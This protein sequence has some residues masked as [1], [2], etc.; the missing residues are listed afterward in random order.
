MRGSVT[1]TGSVE[2][3]GARAVYVRA[4]QGSPLLLIH[5][6]IGG[7]GIWERNIPAL[8]EHR[9]VYAPDL[10]GMGH[11][12]RVH[13]LAAGLEP[14]ARR[15]LAA[16]DA[17]QIDRADVV[18]TSHGGSVALMLAA[19]A[20]E[21]VTSLILLAPAN[22]YS[23]KTD[24]MVRLYSTALGGWIANFA[25]RMP[26]WIQRVALARMFGDRRRMQAGTLKPYHD[27]LQVPGTMAHVLAMVR[28][29]FAEMKKLEAVLPEVAKTPTLLVW[30]DRDRVVSLK[31]AGRLQ[32][33]IGAEL[34]VI[35]GG[36]H[37]VF[38]EFPQETNRI[39]TEWLLRK[40]SAELD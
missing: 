10:L 23:R 35:P 30:G 14:T 5:G 19:L 15:V 2:I 32:R 33:E 29:W 7:Y 21:R 25:P 36:G 18:A 12:E 26:R 31:S 34:V 6:L 17:L 9:T 16:M 20:P 40:G 4:G 3:G 24:W 28:G 13:G 27:A 22:P 37:L 39:M 1:E 11:S 38:E 8:A